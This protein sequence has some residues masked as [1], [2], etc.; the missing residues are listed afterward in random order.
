[1]SY[2]SYSEARMSLHSK[3]SHSKPRKSMRAP[4]REI[5]F[6]PESIAAAKTTLVLR[7]HGNAASNA[8]YLITTEDHIPVYTVSG[9]KSGDRVCREFYDPSGLPLFELHTKT[10]LGRPLSWFITMPGGGS[11]MKIAE[12]Q[13]RWAG[14]QKSMVFSFR[15]MAA[16]DNKREEEKNMSL[17]VTSTG[18]VMARYDIIDGDRRIAGVNESIHHNE[19][20][21][22][23][24]QSRRKSLRPAMDLTVVPGVDT[25]LIA[26]IAVIM[27]EWTYGAE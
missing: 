6:R 1:M 20:L 16:V 12:G 27:F 11:D 7:P 25:L 3:A 5:A 17:L 21:A 10:M 24:P 14:T 19:T 9:R 4:V 15:N 2:T 26:A 18:Q 23:M 22:L 13:P 8:A